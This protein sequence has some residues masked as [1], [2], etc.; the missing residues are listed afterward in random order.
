[1]SRL[2]NKKSRP[3]NIFALLQAETL[4]ARGTFLTR[5]KLFGRM[6]TLRPFDQARNQMSSV[7][8]S[9][10]AVA[11]I[12]SNL[13]TSLCPSFIQDL[14]LTVTPIYRDAL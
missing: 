10:I 5:A 12:A 7:T 13:A 6:N 9:A 14:S 8:A 2:S 1:M 11:V 4:R 3:G